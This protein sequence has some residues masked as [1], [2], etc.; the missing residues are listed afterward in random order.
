MSHTVRM[1]DLLDEALE[2]VAKQ[3]RDDEP[4]PIHRIEVGRNQ[5]RVVWGTY[6][7]YES[8]WFARR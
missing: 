4:E 5:L 2:Y 3:S 7:K 8:P 6:A 1:R